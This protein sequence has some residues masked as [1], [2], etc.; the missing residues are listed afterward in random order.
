MQRY[1]A[2]LAG[3]VAGF[4]GNPTSILPSPTGNLPIQRGGRHGDGSHPGASDGD[5]PHE[6]TGKISGLLFDTF[7]DFEGFILNPGDGECKFFSREREMEVLAEQV[8]RERLRVT[9]LAKRDEPHRPRSII[10]REPP[11]PFGH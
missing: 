6:L 4:G 10:V 11:A 9:V 5:C 8:W 7:G 2:Q 1:I 3:R